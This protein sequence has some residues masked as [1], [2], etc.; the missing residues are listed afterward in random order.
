MYRSSP[1]RRSRPAR[2]ETPSGAGSAG[3]HFDDVVLPTGIR[4]RYLEQGDPAGPAVILLHGLTDSWFSFSRIL[5]GLS[6]VHRI[7]ALDLR[8]HG[9]SDRP[10]DGYTPRD[11]A[12]DVIGFMDVLGIER[13][14]LVGHSMGAFVAREAA[15][16]APNRIAGLVLI[17]SATTLRNEVTL[18]VQ[19]TLESLPDTVPED[20]AMEFQASTIHRDVPQEFL[21]RVIA[22]SRKAPA[23]VWRAALAGLL[24]PSRFTGLGDS[25]IPVLLLWGERDALVSRAEQNA[26]VS[27]LQVASLKVYRETGHAPHWER[28]QDVVRDLER[29]LRT[30]A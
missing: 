22:E 21:A 17:G 24:E 1:R 26:M 4:M 23:R 8:G 13:A 12:E 28:P 9:D 6:P 15:L 3:L 19:H 5:P 10:E 11:M 27:V 25:W 2:V 20:I 16:A 18:E 7:Y 14:T 30:A 29:F